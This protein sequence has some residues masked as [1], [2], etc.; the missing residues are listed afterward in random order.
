MSSRHGSARQR[1][2]LGVTQRA[3]RAHLLL[4]VGAGQA[5][6][7]GRVRAL[8]GVSVLPRAVER[9]QTAL[10]YRDRNRIR[11]GTGIGVRIRTGGG[12]PEARVPYAKVRLLRA[13]AAAGVRPT[14]RVRRRTAE[15]RALENRNTHL[16]AA[17][18]VCTQQPEEQQVHS[19]VNNNN[20][21][22]YTHTIIFV[23]VLGGKV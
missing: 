2:G 22:I 21:Y 17:R 10:R 23:C 6:G 9:A 12:H 19:S 1:R 11:S 3:H 14:G 20:I 18:A 4:P 16:P 8:E 7:L 13:R 5:A 15:S